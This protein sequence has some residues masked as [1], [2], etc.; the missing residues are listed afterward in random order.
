M[1]HDNE[2]ETPTTVKPEFDLNSW[3]PGECVSFRW[4]PEPHYFPTCA[5]SLVYL[6]DEFEDDGRDTTPLSEEAEKTLLELDS[7]FSRT[8]EPAYRTNIEQ[9]WKAWHYERGYQFLLHNYRGGWSLP[10][11]GSAYSAANQQNMASMYATNIY[12]EKTEIVAS[13]LSNEAPEV[14][15][16]PLNPEHGPDEMMAESCDDL[17]D[18]WAKNNNPL[19]ILGDA[20]KIFCISDRVLC[21]N[22]YELN[23]EQYG[24]EESDEQPLVPEAENTELP[25]DE[26]TDPESDLSDMSPVQAPRRPRGR[27]VTRVWDTLN[28][29]VPIYCDD[30]DQMPCVQAME[31]FDV[32]ISKSRYPWIRE[33]IKAGGDTVGASEFSRVARENVR[34][35]LYNRYFTGDTLERHVVEKYTWMRPSLWYDESVK[36]HVREEL[37]AKFPDGCLLV[38]AGEQFAFARNESMDDTLGIAHCRSGMG[39]NRRPLMDSL[40]PVQDYLNEHVC[41]LLDFAKRTIAKKWMNPL[42]FDMEQIKKTGNLPGSIGPFK[43]LPGATSMDSYMMLEPTPQPQPWLVQWVQWI[44][45]SLSEQISGAMPSLFGKGITGQVGSEGVEI[46]RDQALQR[47]SSPWAALQAMFAT[48]AGQAVRLMAKCANSDIDEVIPGRGSVKVKLSQMKGN[49]LCYPVSNPGFPESWAKKEARVMGLLDKISTLPA[50]NPLAESFNDPTNAEEL[51]SILRVKNF[52]IIG[53]DSVRKQRAE[54]EILLR[55][56]PIKNPKKLAL[57]KIISEA[58]QGMAQT[59][60]HVQAG[61]QITAD[62]QSQLKT[63]PAI[64]NSLEQQMKS[65]PDL[66]SSIPVRQDASEGHKYEAQECVNWMNSA[67][68]RKY[69]YGNDQQK[70]AFQNVYLHWQAHDEVAKKIA[71]QEA[72]KPMPKVNISAPINKLPP[73]EAAAAMMGTGV[74][75]TPDDFTNFNNDQLNADISKKVIPEQTYLEGLHKQQDDQPTA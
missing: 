31:D 44:V 41:L 55:Q 74:P 27:V 30:I 2:Q 35:A 8:D 26:P 34:Q 23:G 46:Q 49:V 70:A 68:G 21:I 56:A 37:E 3:V 16:F 45:G 47:M 15:F 9:A 1:A 4:S 40:I 65:L 52:K 64:L 10:G 24:F 13:A 61:G 11:S 38:K 58:A 28:H 62:E 42:A 75:A 5:G 25:A 19:Q 6:P 43:P 29:K 50:G 54:F 60:S 51:Q 32:A 53:S 67:Q 14:E 66:V 36:P 73:K 17:K 48:A 57:Q 12:G 39:Q 71:A 63:A 22:S 69:E 33:K 72:P 20:A 59:I 18:I 7:L